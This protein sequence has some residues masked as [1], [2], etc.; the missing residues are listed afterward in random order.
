MYTVSGL[1]VYCCYS[2]FHIVKR[3]RYDTTDIQLIDL[4]YVIQKL[5]L[6]IFNSRVC[7]ELYRNIT[8]YIITKL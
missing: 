2:Y 8:Y 7:M 3:I 6:L 5:M 1:F 4:N